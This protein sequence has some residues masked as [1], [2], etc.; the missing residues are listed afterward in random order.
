MR[1]FAKA[2][3]MDQLPGGDITIQFNVAVGDALLV[4]NLGK[5]LGTSQFGPLNRNAC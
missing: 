4:R 3:N 5:W 1:D 2:L